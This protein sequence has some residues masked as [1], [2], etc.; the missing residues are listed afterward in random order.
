MDNGLAEDPEKEL[1]DELVELCGEKWRTG[2][3]CCELDQVKALKS[4][5]STPNTIIGSCP[6]CKDN[7]FNMFCTFTCSPDQSTFI[8]ITDSAEKG[9]K[10]LVT[11]LDQLITEEYGSGFYDSCKEVKFGGANSKA[12]DLI[13]GGAKN[14]HEMLK[15]LG[16]KKPLVGSP[17]QI[18][19]PNKSSDHDMEIGRAHV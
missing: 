11:Q 13:G 2:P 17:F 1:R 15:F 14:Y 4:E 16:D 8:N 5:L 9:E 3:V 19:F 6:A 12:M 10:Q 18:N 7:F